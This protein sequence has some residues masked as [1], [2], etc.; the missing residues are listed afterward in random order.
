MPA[1][2]IAKLRGVPR[3][4]E[5]A[6]AVGTCSEGS[7]VG[8]V[9]VGAG[10]GSHPFFIEGGVY[11]TG[12]YKKAPFGLVAVVE[13]KAGPFDLGQVVVRQ[14]LIVDPIDAHVDVVS[15]PLPVILKGVPVRLRSLNVDVNRERFVLNPTSC[16]TKTI[17]AAFSSPNGSVF[18]A[19]VPFGVS[20]CAALPLKPRLR[21]ALTGKGQTTEGKHPGV[22]ATVTQRTSSAN[23]KRVSVRLPL[24]V[25]LDP[26]NAQ[27]LCEFADGTKVDPTCPKG[28]IIGRAVARSPVLDEPLTA[29][30]YFVKN[31][32]IDPRSG[33]P[34][35]TLPMLVI[36]LRGEN[37]IRVNIKGTSSVVQNR[38]V[39]TF[40]ALPDVPVSRFDLAIKGGRHGILASN[41]KICRGKQVADV[42][43]DGQNNRASDRRATLSTPACKSSKRRKAKRD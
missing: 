33:R 29:P 38:L 19:D 1:G 43:I 41:A 3:C 6:A 23:L 17:L 28:S 10:P 18:N 7:R 40:A 37:G 34:I 5:A 22:R 25:A 27:A 4:P 24:S 30:V 16:K 26:D 8:T 12:P 39:S 20:N 35:R 32:R 31:I 11:L 36:P 42:Q 13:A 21:I 15:D 9:T 14:Q 2:L